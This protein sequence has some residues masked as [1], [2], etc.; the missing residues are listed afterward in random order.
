MEKEK[1]KAVINP[2]E[3]SIFKKMVLFALPIMGSSL[4]TTLFSSIDTLVIG[5]FG[6]DNSLSAVGINQSLIML[7]IGNV[8][9]LSIGFSA[10]IGKLY[11]KK[12]IK[13][14]SEIQQSVLLTSLV[15]GLIV[16]AV[17]IPLGKVLLKLINCPE[18]ILDRAYQ[19]FWIYFS[20]SPFLIYNSFENAV[21]SAKGDSFHPLLLGLLAS[22]VN[23]L[24]D[25]LF[26]IVF[27]WDVTGVATA[28]LIAQLFNTVILIVFVQKKGEELKIRWKEQRAFK[29][30]GPVFKL[31]IPTSLDG[32]IMNISGVLISSAI[33]EFDV[34]AI[35]GNTA[36][37]SLES[38]MSIAFVGFANAIIVFISQNYGN[39]NMKRV[40]KSF[41][42]AVITALVLGETI[43]VVIYLCGR[44]LL[45]LFVSNSNPDKAK[46]IDYGLVRLKYMGLFYGLC[47]IMNVLSGANQG[48]GS[49]KIPLVISLVCS[50]AFRITWI[51]AY[52]RPQ[53]SIDLIYVS[54]P[55]CWALSDIASITWFIILS[56]K[57]EKEISS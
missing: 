2:L 42:T 24:L 18:N 12:D 9:G 35:D 26:V 23:V 3:G 50:V 47:A 11:G 21:I 10:I 56:H 44:P 6:L 4:L 41:W 22:A 14:I 39:K 5:N 20:A 52:A 7:I 53:H 55:I 46:I 43:G 49:S 48:L 54:Y 28:T 36:S 32:T 19:Y 37:A 57:R 1:D 31:G 51:Y 45:G 30:L 8:T 33:N 16:M 40:K 17:F 27:H 15:L 25:L 38:L 29:H 34:L 13:S